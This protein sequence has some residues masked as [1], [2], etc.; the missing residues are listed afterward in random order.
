MLYTPGRITGCAL[1]WERFLE[2]NFYESFP[3]PHLRYFAGAKFAAEKCQVVGE[4]HKDVNYANVYIMNTA[5]TNTDFPEINHN[6][7]LASMSPDAQ[8]EAAIAMVANAARNGEKLSPEDARTYVSQLVLA[9]QRPSM[10]FTRDGTAAL[11]NFRRT[12]TALREGLR[13]GNAALRIGAAVV[14]GEA[15]DV[16]LYA[17][18]IPQRTFGLPV[19]GQMGDRLDVL[20]TAL[21][22]GGPQEGTVQEQLVRAYVLPGSSPEMQHDTAVAITRLTRTAD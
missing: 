14:A 9:S 22:I 18:D 11:Q 1:L 8:N 3:P 6:S 21:R 10:E 15:H 17:H 7:I 4:L 13:Y 19:D 5:N 16:T 20:H 2:V 12:V